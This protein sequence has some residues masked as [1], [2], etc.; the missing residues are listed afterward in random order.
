MSEPDARSRSITRASASSSAN[1]AWGLDAAL[2]GTASFVGSGGDRLQD[3]RPTSRAATESQDPPHHDAARV[4]LL[5]IDVEC[6][7][8]GVYCGG[9]RRAF[10]RMSSFSLPSQVLPTSDSLRAA[11]PLLN[12]VALRVSA[13]GGLHNAQRSP[14]S[15]SS[16]REGVAACG[17]GA[18]YAPSC[19]DA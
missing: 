15:A 3:Q 4:I 5:L 17:C 8:G 10:Q 1:D 14:V 18:W 7:G 12:N 9:R 2:A 19:R 6:R 11:R 16:C 13:I